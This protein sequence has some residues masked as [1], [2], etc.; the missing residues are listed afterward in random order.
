MVALVFGMLNIIVADYKGF[1]WFR[2]KVATL[3][4]KTMRHI[5]N[6]IWL[7]LALLVLSGSV[8]FSY[9]QAELLASPAFYMKLLCIVMLSVNGVYIN[10]HMAVASE[11]SFASLPEAEKR[12]LIMSGVV[13]V[14]AWLGAIVLAGFILPE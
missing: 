1:A 4:S 9:H 8:L 13:S 3:P 5:H 7:S 2:G 12:A 10:R 6:H 11:Q 14:V